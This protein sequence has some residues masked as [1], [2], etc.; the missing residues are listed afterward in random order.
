LYIRTKGKVKPRDALISAVE[1]IIKNNKGFTE[2]FKKA[3][4]KS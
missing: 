2:A 3:I 4:K 1:K